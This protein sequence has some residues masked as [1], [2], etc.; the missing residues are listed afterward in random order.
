MD[1]KYPSIYLDDLV[2][3]ARATLRDFKLRVLPV[4]DEKKHLIGVISRKDVMTITSSVSPIRVKGIMSNPSV[5]ITMDMDTA[6]AI[7]EMLRLDKW[8]V[9]VVKSTQDN[10]YVG[11]LGLE[12]VIRKFIE[13]KE[14]KLLTPLSEVMSTKTLLTCSPDDEIVIIWQKMKQLSFAACPVIAKEKPV[15]IVSQHDLLE[16]GAIFPKFESKK[17]KFK[18]TTKI[19]SIMK[20]PVISLKSTNT[21]GDASKLIL[22]RDIGR[23]P[24]TDAKGNFIGIIDREDLV[25]ALT[26]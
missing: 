18:T 25:K 8:Y 5:T 13:K 21:I 2:T 26:K 7:R 1:Q 23:V 3:K 22:E 9:P 11:L 17:G 20:T 4:I 14:V 16:S 6:Q 10:T 19:F 24:I 15:G 12:H